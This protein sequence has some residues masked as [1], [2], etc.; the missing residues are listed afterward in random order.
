MGGEPAVAATHECRYVV[1]YG[2]VMDM[3]CGAR[4]TELERGCHCSVIITKNVYT[5]I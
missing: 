5:Y 4:F 3:G 1:V 2:T